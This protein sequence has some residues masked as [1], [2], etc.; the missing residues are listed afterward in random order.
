VKFINP[1]HGEKLHD[2][3]NQAIALH[4]PEVEGVI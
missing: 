4:M 2:V 1:G 3:F